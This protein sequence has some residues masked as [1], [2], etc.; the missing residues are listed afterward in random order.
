MPAAAVIPVAEVAGLD[1]V[2]L[3]GNVVSEPWVVSRPW[4][5]T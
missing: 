2:D 1:R 5:I 3:L 4:L